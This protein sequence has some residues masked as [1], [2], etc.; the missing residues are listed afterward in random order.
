LKPSPWPYPAIFGIY[1]ISMVEETT[2]WWENVEFA[3]E[4]SSSSSSEETELLI[5]TLRM[6]MKR[7]KKYA[8]G[9]KKKVRRL[10]RGTPR[11]P[12]ES[13]YRRWRD[14][15]TRKEWF[16]LLQ[17][18]DLLDT[19]SRAA[20][21]FQRDFRIPFRVYRFLYI[22]AKDATKE[23]GATPLWPATDALNIPTH[24]LSVKILCALYVLGQGAP[25]RTCEGRSG[26]DEDT[27]RVFFHEFNKWM[28]L[29]FYDEWITIPYDRDLQAIVADYTS[30]GLP[31][32]GTSGKSHMPLCRNVC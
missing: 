19:E 30:L 4:S 12:I 20:K 9:A 17:N 25:F 3:S 1:Y 2:Y 18:P 5:R 26:I 21:E 22:K 11:G 15:P 10:A 27:V 28:V 8:S 32:A 14:D 16:L 7:C 13:G 6:T 24:P 23:D 29:S 31:G